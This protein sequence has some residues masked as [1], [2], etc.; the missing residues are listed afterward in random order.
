MQWTER[1]RTR[2][3]YTHRDDLENQSMKLFCLISIQFSALTSRSKW[4]RF[5]FLS[6][7]DIKKFTSD[8]VEREVEQSENL[9]PQNLPEAAEVASI[10][11]LARIWDCHVVSVEWNL[12]L[13]GIWILTF[14]FC[15]RSD[16]QHLEMINI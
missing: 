14:E 3:L 12:K 4:F 2:L 9:L 7:R 11:N 10:W 16:V 5:E 6:R 13:H 8:Q 1:E 15:Y